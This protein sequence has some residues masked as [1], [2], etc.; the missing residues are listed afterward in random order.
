MPNTKSHTPTSL[1]EFAHARNWVQQRM[2]MGALSPDDLPYKISKKNEYIK[3]RGMFHS[4]LVV[5]TNDN[6]FELAA[7]QSYLGHGS[8]AKVKTILWEDGQESKVTIMHGSSMQFWYPEEEDKNQ[9]IKLMT[10]IER[11]VHD[12]PALYFSRKAKTSESEVDTKYYITGQLFA[13]ET[14]ANYLS[15]KRFLTA[16]FY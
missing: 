12:Y 4:F 6:N 3:N 16:K 7:Y 9:K 2:D 5:P 14:L 15:H 13:G 8:Q 10:D 1:E 11:K